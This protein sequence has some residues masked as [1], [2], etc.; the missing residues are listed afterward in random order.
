[1]P[2]QR[3]RDGSQNIVLFRG[4][5]DDYFLTVYIRRVQFRIR[6]ESG[7]FRIL[8]KEEVYDP[9]RPPIIVTVAKSRLL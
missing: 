3:N 2:I 5:F 4:L 9:K 7:C 1:M 8:H 6:A